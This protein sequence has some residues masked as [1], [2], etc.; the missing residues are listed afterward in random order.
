M[1]HCGS[2]YW[3]TQSAPECSS[4]VHS[5]TNP[6]R[7]LCEVVPFSIPTINCVT[8]A[9]YCCSVDNIIVHMSCEPLALCA[10]G[11][12]ACLVCAYWVC[13]VWHCVHVCMVCISTCMLTVVS[14]SC[15]SELLLSFSATRDTSTPLLMMNT[16]RPLTLSF[17]IIIVI[18]NNYADR[19]I[20]FCMLCVLFIQFEHTCQLYIRMLLLWC[21]RMVYTIPIFYLCSST[22]IHAVVCTSCMHM[23]NSTAAG[24]YIQMCTIITYYMHVYVILCIIASTLHAATKWIL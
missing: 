13:E 8:C 21:V 19:K 9:P 22:R 17:V 10:V 2:S 14:I 11:L 16:S 12:C 5:V 1:F 3:H 23:Y 18:S 24:V 7:S 6:T 20:Y 15:P 4:S